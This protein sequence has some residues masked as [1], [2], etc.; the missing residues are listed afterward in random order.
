M[1]DPIIPE[2]YADLH[3]AASSVHIDGI[4]RPWQH[5]SHAPS[6]LLLVGE[7]PHHP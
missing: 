5:P 2:R 6:C 4:H 1:P 7:R 3:R